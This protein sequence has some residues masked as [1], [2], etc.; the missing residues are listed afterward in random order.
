MAKPSG[1][2]SPR[3]SLVCK[4]DISKA[5]RALRVSRV[6]RSGCPM[7]GPFLRHQ[8]GYSTRDPPLPIPNREVKPRHADGTA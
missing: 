1:T 7:S 4:V 2:N 8:G 3:L 6:N 5:L